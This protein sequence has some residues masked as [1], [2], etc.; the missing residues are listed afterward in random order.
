MAKRFVLQRQSYRESI[1]IIWRSFFRIIYAFDSVDIFLLQMT[2]EEKIH[3][4]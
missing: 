1:I 3:H 4:P 2:D